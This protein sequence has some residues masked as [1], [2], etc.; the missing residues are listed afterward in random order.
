MADRTAIQ[1]MESVYRRTDK[2]IRDLLQDYQRDTFGDPEI[3]TINV[4]VG[5]GVS[6]L[7]PGVAAAIRLDFQARITGFYLQEFDGTTGSVAITVQRAQG[8]PAPVWANMSPTTPVGIV[9]GRYFAE[10]DPIATWP[11]TTLERDDYLRFVVASATAI[12][13]VHVALRI[14]RL[15]P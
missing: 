9:S 15:E 12:M 14:R 7:A 5:D 10:T 8:G 11:A 1:F 3:D 2:Q 13:R 4:I 6:V